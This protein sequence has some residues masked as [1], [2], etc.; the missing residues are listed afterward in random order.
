[1]ATRQR[2]KKRSKRAPT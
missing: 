1:A 2:S